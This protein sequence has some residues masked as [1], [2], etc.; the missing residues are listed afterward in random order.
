MNITLQTQLVSLSFLN[1]HA[2]LIFYLS[3]CLCG[4]LEHFG[5]QAPDLSFFYLSIWFDSSRFENWF[6]DRQGGV[7]GAFTQNC[8]V[9]LPASAS[10]ES[11]SSS[12]DG[13]DGFHDIPFSANW[14][15]V[16][17]PVTDSF[18]SSGSTTASASTVVDS[19][20]RP[21]SLDSSSSDATIIV[22]AA[23][24]VPMDMSISY[25]GDSSFTSPSK[26]PSPAMEVTVSTQQV[27]SAATGPAITV[28]SS[29]IPHLPVLSHGDMRS[30]LPRNVTFEKL[31]IPGRS[32]QTPEASR[33]VMMNVIQ[34]LSALS[35]VTTH[36]PV[37]LIIKANPNNKVPPV[38]LS[39]GG[40]AFGN[41]NTSLQQ[42]S[43]SATEVAGESLSLSGPRCGRSRL[44]SLKNKSTPECEDTPVVSSS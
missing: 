35:S 34:E 43:G 17:P 16:S 27:A 39:L 37:Q 20:T 18:F 41:L 31:L 30:Q 15:P 32:T 2:I 24:P 38:S 23:Q 29:G 9:R 22:S 14:N 1:I 3:F 6:I 10:P 21:P 4:A 11:D 26:V 40:K 8:F 36:N 33:V 25:G 12:D 42:P 7:I 13:D 19:S 28:S 5:Y 44:T